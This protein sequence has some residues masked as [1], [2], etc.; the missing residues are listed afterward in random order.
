M[1]N[2]RAQISPDAAASIAFAA[3]KVQRTRSQVIQWMLEK[4][5]QDVSAQQLAAGLAADLF[6]SVSSVHVEL[7]GLPDEEA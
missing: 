6:Q 3:R 4:L 2:I 7:S 1:V 5:C